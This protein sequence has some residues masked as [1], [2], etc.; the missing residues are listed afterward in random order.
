MTPSDKQKQKE[1]EI[2]EV[3][4]GCDK[5]IKRIKKRRVSTVLFRRALEEL[6]DGIDEILNDNG[7]DSLFNGVPKC[8]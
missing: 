4:Q 3:I 6:E 2:E 8:S 1:L 5:G 7:S